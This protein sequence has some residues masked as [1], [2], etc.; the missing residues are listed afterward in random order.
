[1]HWYEGRSC[2]ICRAP[3]QEKARRGRPLLRAATGT[4]VEPEGL[5]PDEIEALFH[6]HRAVCWDCNLDQAFAAPARAPVTPAPPAARNGR[7]WW[8]GR[9][10]VVCVKPV[11]RLRF[12]HDKP[13]LV[14]RTG[15]SRDVRSVPADE[16]ERALES[17]SLVCPG[18]Y[19][20]RHGEA[21]TAAR[22]P[23]SST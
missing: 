9:T 4:T 13:R 23:R 3:L 6:T 22:S 5:S 19:Y 20:H 8:E 10:C 17:S 11:G 21:L 2:S 14:S 15:T 1:M 7:P 18:C 12:W 16:V